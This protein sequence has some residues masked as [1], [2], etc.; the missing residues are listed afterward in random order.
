MN[1]VAESYAGLSYKSITE[2][3]IILVSPGPRCLGALQSR[4]SLVRGTGEKILAMWA[5]TK[6]SI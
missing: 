6:V 3:R 1:D 5:V 4:N 2:H